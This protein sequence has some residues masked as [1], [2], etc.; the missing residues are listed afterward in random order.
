[1]KGKFLTV[2]VLTCLALSTAWAANDDANTRNVASYLTTSSINQVMQGEHAQDWMKRTI[3]NVS[4]QKNFTPQYEVETIQPITKVDTDTKHVVFTQARVAH[5]TD[6]GT[7]A[8][9][10]FGYRHL[11]DNKTA[12]AG[13]NAF[14]DHGFRHNHN[15]MSAGVEYFH[16]QNEFRMN[17]YRGLSGAREVDNVNHIFEKVVNG[18]DIGYAHTFTDAEW[19]KAY[20]NLY[21]WDMEHHDDAKGMSVGAELQLTPNISLDFGYNKVNNYSGNMYGKIMYRL[22]ES[23][24]AL[25][26]GAHTYGTNHTVESKLLTKVRRQN[27]IIVETSSSNKKVDSSTLQYVIRVI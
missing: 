4:F 24:V 22:G 19:A 3:V 15:R 14:F 5:S 21:H 23:P 13:V 12:L 25:W 16:G 27:N 9:I 1:M 8:N 20:I 11:N 26:G 17:L 18:Y 6:L 10:G 2:G 7:T